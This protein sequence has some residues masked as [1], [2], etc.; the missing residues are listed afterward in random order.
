MDLTHAGYLV[1][2]IVVTQEM[3]ALIVRIMAMSDAFILRRI[4]FVIGKFV[5]Q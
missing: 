2:H 3:N 1:E 4:A 5:G